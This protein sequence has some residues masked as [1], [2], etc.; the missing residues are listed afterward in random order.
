M[1]TCAAS[2]HTALESV[3]GAFASHGGSFAPLAHVYRALWLNADDEVLLA[4]HGERVRIVGVTS[5]HGLL[6]TV[7]V[8]STLTARDDRAWGPSG[9][10]D[11]IELQPDG[12]TYDMLH[13]MVRQR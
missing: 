9:A 5:D 7:P 1:E 2:V 10:V 11:S 4:E 8:A 3:L 6:R 13:N 12:N